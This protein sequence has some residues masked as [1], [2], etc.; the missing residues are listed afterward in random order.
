M[1]NQDRTLLIGSIALNVAL[2][3]AVA[4]LASRPGPSPEATQVAQVNTPTSAVTPTSAPSPSSAP[5]PT[6]VIVTVVVSATPAPTARPT[7]TPAPTA[8][9]AAT[10][11]P[12]AAPTETP[13]ETPT[14]TPTAVP[15]ETPIALTGPNWLRYA[16]QFR[17]QAG[18]PPVTENADWSE[19]SANHSLYMV[20]NSDTSHSESKNQIGYTE[21][22][23]AAGQNGNIA[24][25][26]SAGVGYTWPLDYWMSASFHALPLLDPELQMVGY[27]DFRDAS[28]SFG[29]AATM[30]VKRGIRGL[31]ADIQFPITFPKDGGQTWVTTFNLPEFPN[32][33]ASCPGFSQPTGAPII[34][35]IGSGDRVPRVTSTELKRGDTPV[36]HCSFSETT[37]TNPN[38]YWQGVGRLILDVRDAIVIVPRSPLVVG[39]KY[40]VTVNTNG[41]VITWQFDV[42]AGPPT[43]GS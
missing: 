14:K 35:Q 36:P 33:I 15:T 3:I 18:L 21:S 34:L 25:S 11:V 26:G 10:A 23:A 42:V 19:G 30:D 16:N 32:S 13:T 27:G 39:Q 8:T 5:S 12:S 28:S 40:T 29:M 37:Y 24:V 6:A 9:A 38:S 7:E 4:F 43:N 41:Q 2:L 17:L 31:P 22:G 1:K 20:L